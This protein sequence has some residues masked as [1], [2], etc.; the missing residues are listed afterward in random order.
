MSFCGQGDALGE[1]HPFSLAFTALTV[2]PLPKILNKNGDAD[3]H[4]VEAKKNKNF[5][6]MNRFFSVLMVAMMAISM[7]FVACKKDD[8][9][10][11]DNSGLKGIAF[12]EEDITLSVGQKYT[13]ELL[14]TPSKADLPDCTFTS[15]D[16][17]VATVNRTSGQITAVGEGEAIITAT[18][19]DGKFSAKCYVTV[20][21][22]ENPPPPPPPPGGGYVIEAKNVQFAD[23]AGIANVN[24]YMGGEEASNILATAKFSN[25]SFKLNLPETVQDKF[26]KDWGGP[27]MGELW[28]V[29][30]DAGNNII[31]QFY[32]FGV[33]EGEAYWGGWY[34]YVK[35][36]YQDDYISLKKG[37]NQI[38]W[39]YD[40]NTNELKGYTTSEPAGTVW[41]FNNGGKKAG[42]QAI[43]QKLQNIKGR[44]GLK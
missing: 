8:K 36:A 35:A 21:D 20:T 41:V 29:A 38:F 24:A 28:P 39:V 42:N 14:T 3:S 2:I 26:L 12:E 9:G 19:D 7:T 1:K 11:S 17:N 18:T 10:S 23:G 34:Y 13:P 22:G 30:T 31:G 43:H 25:N 15:D 44:K 16:K 40:I 32:K 27:V 6:I 5:Y 33:S 4:K 37:W